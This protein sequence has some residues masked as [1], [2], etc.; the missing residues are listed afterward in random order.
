M[1]RQ[2]REAAAPQPDSRTAVTP[3]VERE[4]WPGI[5]AL[6]S[7]HEWRGSGVPAREGGRPWEEEGR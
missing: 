4:I 2:G 1:R 3:R 6:S 5:H 7:P